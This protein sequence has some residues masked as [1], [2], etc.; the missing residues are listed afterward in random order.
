MKQ[1]LSD[2]R[3]DYSQNFIDFTKIPANPYKLFNDWYQAVHESGLISE[4][5]AMNLSTLGVDGFPRTRVVL[6]REFSEDGFI[7]YTNYHSQKGHAIAEKPCVCISFFWDKLERQVIIKGNVEKVDA[8][9]S[10]EYFQKRPVESQVGAL[11]SAQSSV[12]P[13]DLDLDAEVK[14]LQQQFEGKEVPRPPHWG[15][16]CVKPV[17]FE[18]WQGRP[19]RLHDRLRYRWEQGVWIAER[20]AP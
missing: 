12:I 3:K 2:K 13:F 11:V 4:P 7:F 10:D 18:F 15:G 19:S 17:E 6:L 8:A 20:L 14:K 5:Y 16:Y 9:V 1:D